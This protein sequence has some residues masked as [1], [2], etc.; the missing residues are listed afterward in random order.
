MA[1]IRLVSLPELLL[2]SILSYLPVLY[3]LSRFTKGIRYFLS[4][5]TLA[6]TWNVEGG[7]AGPGRLGNNEVHIALATAD[8]N[9]FGLRFFE[10]IGQFFSCFRVG[11]DF[12]K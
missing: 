3:P 4:G 5:N 1:A 8:N 6:K 11:I 12:H 9:F 7:T 10:D 2:L